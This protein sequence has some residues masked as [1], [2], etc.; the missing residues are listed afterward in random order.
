MLQQLQSCSSARCRFQNS[1]VA[2]KIPKSHK[3]W[4]RSK[5]RGHVSSHS[6][7]VMIRTSGYQRKEEKFQQWTR[8]AAGAAGLTNPCHHLDRIYG[9]LAQGHRTKSLGVRIAGR[10]QV[11]FCSTRHPDSP[12]YLG[13]HS[14]LES[15]VAALSTDLTPVVQRAHTHTRCVSSM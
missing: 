13:L 1:H 4:I 9:L 8:P 11:S 3:S 5:R 10:Y 12:F 6:L 2:V 14:L 7:P 15:S